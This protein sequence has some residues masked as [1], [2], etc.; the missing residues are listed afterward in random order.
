MFVTEITRHCTGDG[1]SVRNYDMFV[2]GKVI[3]SE[4]RSKIDLTELISTTVCE[5]DSCFITIVNVYKVTDIYHIY[6]LS[7]SGDKTKIF[8]LYKKSMDEHNF[9]QLKMT[10]VYSTFL[11]NISYNDFLD[12]K[13]LF[14]NIINTVNSNK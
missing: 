2:N 1:L 10:P 11:G 4:I 7:S 5:K 6:L 3:S 12:N 13:E 9:L 14:F 8:N